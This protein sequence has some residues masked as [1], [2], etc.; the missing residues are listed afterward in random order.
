[1]SDEL[2]DNLRAV[3]DFFGL[4]GSA[5]VAKD[6]HVVRAIKVLAAIDAAPFR[7]VFGGGT[8]L[9]RA[10]RIVRR[11]SEDVDFKVVAQASARVSR[12]ALRRQLDQLRERISQALLD[13]GFPFDRTDKSVTWARDEGRYAV[14]HL[15]YASETG[16]G[17]GLRP[18]IQIETTYA[19]LRQAAVT[20]PVSSFV[21]E[22]NRRDPEVPGLACVSVTETAAEKL[23]SLT[24]RTAMDL[25]GASRDSDPTLVRHIY[26]LHMMRGHLDFAAVA[27]LARVIAAADA[28]QFARQH[29]AY[30][31]DIAGETLKAVAA[32]R[33]DP[34]YRARY[35]R[36]VAA[37][38]YGETPDF[39]AAM[40][41]V[42]DLWLGA[43]AVGTE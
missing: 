27:A 18:T 1:M 15:P 13:A 34:L 32:L 42:A 26:D 5:L 4:P 9:A 33:T 6:F 20:V 22:A 12:S 29:P 16:A 35:G 30:A 36:F 40:A 41:T 23:V 11:M 17:E 28:E 24:R 39:A 43:G 37:M 2:P 19:T 31:A 7:L 38:V 14:W 8:A 3:A 25:A 10:H 21:A